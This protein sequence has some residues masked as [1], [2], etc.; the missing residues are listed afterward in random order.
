MRPAKLLPAKC[1]KIRRLSQPVSDTLKAI[2]LAAG[3][4][5][6]L[7]PLGE[8]SVL[9]CVIQNALDNAAPEDIY[10]VVGSTQ[11]EVRA[12]LG[13]RY[14]YVIQESPLGTGDAVRHAICLLPD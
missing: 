4:S 2:V 6:L 1:P 13:G 9:E 12:H 3:N 8:R 10:V 7:E 11:A 5:I 14:R